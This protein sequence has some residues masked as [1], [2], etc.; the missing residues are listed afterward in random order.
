MPYFL[1]FFLN[2]RVSVFRHFS[3]LLPN[4]LAIFL[5]IASINTCISPQNISCN[6]L[7]LILPS[8]FE[9]F[10]FNPLILSRFALLLQS[11]LS[12]LWRLLIK[13]LETGIFF[14]GFF[15]PTFQ[16]CCA[17]NATWK[18]KRYY[19]IYNKKI[20]EI[21]SFIKFEIWKVSIHFSLSIENVKFA[22]KK[23][24]QFPR[25]ASSKW[26]ITFFNAMSA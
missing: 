7:S 9:S 1:L 16:C 2:I 21:L 18:I 6:I 19:D 25:L 12:F 3:V 20:Y 23:K 8:V 24:I 4:F 26:K 22:L 10:L 14:K 13:S 17:N 5:F 11:S 15:P